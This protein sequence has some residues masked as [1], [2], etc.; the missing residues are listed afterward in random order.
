MVS[1]E[2]EEFL[3]EKA[4][5]GTPQEK[6]TLFSAP[7][8]V[9]ND[10][11]ERKRGE[12][13]LKKLQIE[14]D[15]LEKPNTSIDYFQKMLELQQ[16][17]FNQQIQMVQQQNDLKLEIEKLKLMGDGNSDSMLP[18]LQ[19][20]APLIPELMKKQK[21][22]KTTGSTG[23]TGLKS[24]EKAEEVQEVE[25]EDRNQIQDLEEYKAAIK[26]GEIS[27]EEAYE[28]FLQTPWKNSLTKEQFKAKYDE[29]RA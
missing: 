21:Q 11:I 8:P 17:H 12:L 27:F 25:K 9:T 23:S 7:T 4:P 14:I 19:M 22:Q 16:L 24:E 6:K 18:Y 3:K 10:D 20:L 26:R 2:T 29:L 28:D 1:K 5:L 13:E 15:R